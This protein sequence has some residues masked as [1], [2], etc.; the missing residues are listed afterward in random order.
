MDS[1]G[2]NRCCG[3]IAVAEEAP[4]DARETSIGDTTKAVL[5]DTAL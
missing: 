4:M 2:D 5:P 3:A 1:A